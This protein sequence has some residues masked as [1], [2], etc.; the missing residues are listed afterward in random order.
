MP[1]KIWIWLSI[2]LVYVVLLGLLL[3]YAFF[4]DEDDETITYDSNGNYW[5]TFYENEEDGTWG[6]AFEAASGE[7]FVAIR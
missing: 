6:T 1:S 4:G 2:I 5:T 3:V 7:Y